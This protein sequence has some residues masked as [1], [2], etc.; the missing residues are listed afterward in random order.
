MSNP[1][2]R[3]TPFD[4]PVAG[5]GGS[6]RAMVDIDGDNDLDGFAGN[7]DGTISFLRNM[8]T[9]THPVFAAP[10]TNPFGLKDVGSK[11]APT[12]VDIDNDGDLD[13]FVGNNGG[14]T[15]F[16]RNEGTANNPKFVAAGINPF[17]LS[18]V[19]FRAGPT[20][21]DIDG[22]GDFDAFIGNGNWQTLFFE[23][24]GTISNPIF[25]AN[26]SLNFGGYPNFVDIDYDDDLDVFCDV[27]GGLAFYRN[28][29][30]INNPRYYFDSYNPF[31]LSWVDSFADID[32][33]GDWDTSISDYGFMQNTGPGYSPSFRGFSQ[34]D[35]GRIYYAN[36]EIV[37]I[38]N[39]G[40]F[41]MFVSSG[42]EN[43]TRFY[44]NTGTITNPS[45]AAAVDNPFGLGNT[46]SSDRLTFVDIDGDGDFDSFSKTYSND[47]LFSQ[48]IGTSDAPAFAAAVTHPFD[49][50]HNGSAID[51]A[52]ID[53]DGDSDV[54]VI[55]DSGLQ[56]FLNTGTAV[57][58]SFAPAVTAPPGLG[59][60]RSG[61]SFVDIDGDGDLDAFGGSYGYVHFMPN[62]GTASSPD[63]TFQSGS[64]NVFLPGEGGR[65]PT[66]NSPVFADMDGD[67][68][69]DA[70]IGRYLG[71]GYFV[72][73]NAPNAFNLSTV[74]IYKPN[75][76]LNLDN[77]VIEDPDSD[78]VTA[79]LTLSNVAAGSLSTR[80][81]GTV[82]SVFDAATGVWSASGALADVNTLLAGVFFTPASNFSGNF[83]IDTS[84]SDGVAAPLLG[85]KSFTVAVDAMLFSTPGNDNLIGTPSLNDTASYENATAPV[86]VSLNIVTQQ[87]TLGAGL[88]TLNDIENLIGSNFA[89]HLTGNT[90]NNILQGRSGND[91]LT[92]WS[93]EDT[94]IGGPGNDSYF[95]ENTSDTV[96]EA[97]NQGIDSV[98]SSVTYT[99]P[100]NVENLILRGSSA[101][102]GTG[103]GQANTITGNVASNVLK[104]GAGNDILLGGAGNDTL[105]GGIGRDT[106][107]GGFGADVLKGGSGNDNYVVDNTGDSII[108]AAGGGIDGVNS[109]ATF[110]LPAQ[111]ENLT[112]TGAAA[113]NG[114]GN[115]LANVIIGNAGKNQL[116]GAAGNDILDGRQGTDILT[117]GI[118]NDIFRFTTMGQ[119]DT[120]TDFNV[121]NDTIQLENAVFTALTVTGTLAAGRFRIG[122]NAL[123]ANDN[124]IYNSATGALIYDA[125]GSGAGAAVQIATIGTGLALTHADIVVI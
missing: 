7:Y 99:L 4:P 26:N 66:D 33:D 83:S 119:I 94:M 78:N 51:F 81:S 76:F 107:D 40:D 22:D 63:F 116:K 113:I 86:T 1:V 59:G 104:G 3:Y 41:D 30:T 58:P 11:S 112:L 62:N 97:L 9:A 101:I 124:I 46:D 77:I 60:G 103:N 53:D 68:D 52:D 10:I 108:E 65:Y 29:G 37:D 50:S 111:V 47:I 48:N 16:F 102:N 24:T 34:F 110:A 74:E 12:F 72:N 20:F 17:G 98:N 8:G 79:I 45:F 64:M 100:D 27:G 123:D 19:G 21:A 55:N 6:F 32:D 73:N 87:N 92:G 109:S 122:A 14:N 56:F 115:N 28:I 23:N 2:F 49:F 125:N 117:G 18:D 25:I 44:Q 91:V 82:A 90:A 69:F 39:D 89:D 36:P 88:D 120:I 5:Y 93:G 105:E 106:L 54:F 38:D 121:V 80:T 114:T 67:G 15:R 43:I 70:F 75:T 96:I 118:G 35:F 61:L 84:I 85:S 71:V 57:S 42:F 95:V 13:A 31:G